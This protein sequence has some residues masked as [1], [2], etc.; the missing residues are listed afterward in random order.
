VAVVNQKYWVHDALNDRFSAAIIC[1]NKGMETLSALDELLDP[2]AGWLTPQA[3]Q[4]LVD[5]KPSEALRQRIEEL[6]VKSN[7]GKLTPEEDA[8]YRAYLDDAELICLMQAKARQ[9]YRTK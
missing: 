5:W 8:E 7:H 4:R 1:Y 6:G 9:N 3:A 2:N